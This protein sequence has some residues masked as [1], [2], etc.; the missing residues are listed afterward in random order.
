MKKLFV[1]L[2]SLGLALGASAQRGGHVGG[3]HFGGGYAHSPRVFIGGGFG[4]GYGFGPYY[5]YYGLY[6]PWGFG[7]PPPYY[8][9]YG[10]MP[11]RLAVQIEG[12]KSD[13]KEE[14]KMTRHDKTLTHADKR[15][16]IKQLKTDRDQ[17]VVQAR[18]DFYNNSRRNY[19]KNNGNGQ[20]NEN[21]QNNNGQNYN[22]PNNNNNSQ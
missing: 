2:F 8:Y 13:A 10:A 18:K 1:I 17:A 22:S 3:G 16:K 12:I 7:Y 15:A 6:S 9:G 21:G 4:Y 5:P 19:N 20:N 11:S 14:I